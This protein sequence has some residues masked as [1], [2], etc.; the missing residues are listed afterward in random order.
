[1]EMC[2]TTSVS[3]GITALILS[4]D[5]IIYTGKMRL[6]IKRG[7]LKMRKSLI[8]LGFAAAAASL[9]VLSGCS[10]TQLSPAARKVMITNNQKIPKGCKYLGSATA[11]QGNFFTGGFTSNKNLQQGSFN[12]LRNQA[13]TMGGNRVVLLM[14][15]AANTGGWSNGSGSM[16]ETNVALTGNVYKCRHQ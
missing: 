5:L 8:A 13:A 14:S 9:L 4:L 2:E 10:A 15:H 12:D 7:N 11:N 1:M 16:Q 6:F 3:A